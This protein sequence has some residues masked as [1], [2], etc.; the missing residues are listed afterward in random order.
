MAPEQTPESEALPQQAA[1]R[2]LSFTPLRPQNAASLVPLLYDWDVVKMLADMPW[3]VDLEYIANRAA[4]Q[5]GPN[6]EAVEFIILIGGT[7]IGSCIIKKPGSGDPPRRMPRLGYW[8]GRPYW[9]RGYG[10]QAVAWLVNYAFRSFPQHVVGAGVFDDNVASRRLLE[11]LGF[12]NFGSYE[13]HCP[14]R[15]ARVNVIDMQ[16]SRSQLKSRRSAGP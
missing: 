1:P 4:R 7:A 15:G 16:L 6:P 9:R 14:S 10:T 13:L 5:L 3:P 11:K 8:I 12:T 2:P